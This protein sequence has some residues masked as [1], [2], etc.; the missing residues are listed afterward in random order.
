MLALGAIE[1]REARA[2]ARRVVAQA[3]ARAVSAGLVTVAVQRIRARRTLY[4]E[5][6][7][8]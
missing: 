7:Q 4:R 2:G 1:A 6:K 5:N 8:I 3:P